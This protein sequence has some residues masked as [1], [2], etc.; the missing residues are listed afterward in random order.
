MGMNAKQAIIGGGFLCALSL[1][2]LA[3]SASPS[4]LWQNPQICS[5]VSCS[6]AAGNGVFVRVGDFSSDVLRSMDGTHW[7]RH[8]SGVLSS[9]YSVTFGEGRFVAVGNEGALVTSVDGVTWTSVNS[10]TDERLR[11]VVYAHGMF[12]AVGYNGTIITSPTGLV[13]KV[14]DSKT[15][16]R[17]H[18]VSFGNSLYVALG[19]NGQVVSS[20]D[21]KHW[22]QGPALDGAFATLGFTNGTFTTANAEGTA[23]SSKDANT[24]QATGAFIASAQ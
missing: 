14:R 21:G 3:Q 1:N 6:T 8:S 18:A 9:L 4:G 2:S 19:K 17:L 11:N 7:V 16:E 22:K 5:A 15:A 20:R 13:W 12:V 23:F 10:A 24:W